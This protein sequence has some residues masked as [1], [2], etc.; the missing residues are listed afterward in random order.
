MRRGQAVH[1]VEAVTLSEPQVP[2]ALAASGPPVVLTQ[3][4]GQILHTFWPTS[5]VYVPASQG[6]QKGV[7]GDPAK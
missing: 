2:S 4:A 5:S 1:C 7:S 3:P 6:E